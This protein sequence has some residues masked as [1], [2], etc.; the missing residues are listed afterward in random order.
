MEESLEEGTWKKLQ[1]IQLGYSL[2]QNPLRKLFR[3]AL[4]LILVKVLNNYE[5]MLQ[6]RS[7]K[8]SAALKDHPLFEGDVLSH[9][10]EYIGTNT[11]FQYRIKA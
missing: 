11:Y 10:F 9:K 7:A 5:M 6:M 4:F 2:K 3:T 8:L 1:A